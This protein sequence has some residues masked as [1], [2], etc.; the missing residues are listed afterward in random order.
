MTSY[1]ILSH[2]G[3][4]LSVLGAKNA[5]EGSLTPKKSVFLPPNLGV[6]EVRYSVKRCELHVIDVP[7]HVSEIPVFLQICVQIGA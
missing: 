7:V 4:D 6:G 2:L 1:W 3:A 5:I